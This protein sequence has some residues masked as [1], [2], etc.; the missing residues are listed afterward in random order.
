MQTYPYPTP[1]GII[2]LVRKTEYDRLKW[3][4]EETKTANAELLDRLR[5]ARES[6]LAASARDVQTIQRQAVLLAKLRDAAANAGCLGWFLDA[7]ESVAKDHAETPAS[8]ATG[9]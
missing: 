7:Y 5:E 4:L 8:T 9:R 2:D 1:D 3:E 6:H